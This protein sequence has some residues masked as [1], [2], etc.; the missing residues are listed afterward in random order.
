MAGEHHTREVG[1]Q[2][3]IGKA[4]QDCIENVER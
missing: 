4:L 1:Q 2:R 3:R